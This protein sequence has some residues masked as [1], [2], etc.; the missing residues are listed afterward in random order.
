[1]RLDHLLSRERELEFA[2]SASVKHPP[3]LIAP[4]VPSTPLG[5]GGGRIRPAE[6]ESD[7][8]TDH[9]N[10]LTQAFLPLFKC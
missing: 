2:V 4:I 6:I 7:P 8:A 3:R 9:R 1:M 10:S 5:G